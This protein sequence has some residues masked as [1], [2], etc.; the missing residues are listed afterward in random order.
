M[1]YW[2]K[3]FENMFLARRAPVYGRIH[4]H[5]CNSNAL[6]QP[7]FTAIP[8]VSFQFLNYSLRC[9]LYKRLEI[10]ATHVF[11]RLS[12]KQLNWFSLRVHHSK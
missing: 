10:G 4:V 1:F 12:W 5:H 8:M 7:S 9:Y 2:V 11:K 6:Y 3:R